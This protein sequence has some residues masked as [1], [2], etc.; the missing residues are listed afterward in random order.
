MTELQEGSWISA[1]PMR[2]G[3]TSEFLGIHPTVETLAAQCVLVAALLAA[4]GWTLVVRPWRAAAARRSGPPAI[5][6]PRLTAARRLSREERPWPSPGAP[7]NCPP[8]DA[9]RS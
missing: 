6:A 3:P 9:P 1:T 4:L 2:G 5:R 7:Q 8:R